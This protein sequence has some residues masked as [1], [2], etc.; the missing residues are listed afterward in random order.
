MKRRAIHFSTSD[1]SDENGKWKFSTLCGL[2]DFGK[3]D[4]L[5]VD[6]TRDE[7]AVTCKTCARKLEKS[8]PNALVTGIQVKP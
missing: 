8:A 6:C 2:G 1:F 5:T 3:R 7:K 4:S